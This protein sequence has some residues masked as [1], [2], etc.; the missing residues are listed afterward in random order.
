MRVEPTNRVP[1]NLSPLHKASQATEPSSTSLYSQKLSF[2][3]NK[4]LNS[5]TRHYIHA[6]LPWTNK[7]M[8]V[9][10]CW[11]PRALTTLNMKGWTTKCSP[12]RHAEQLTRKKEHPQC[13]NGNMPLQ[14]VP[15][16]IEAVRSVWGLKNQMEVTILK[17][18]YLLRK[19]VWGIC[20]CIGFDLP[21]VLRRFG[22]PW[23]CTDTGNWIC[24]EMLCWDNTFFT[25][26]RALFL[27][28]LKLKMTDNGIKQTK[29]L[30]KQCRFCACDSLAFFFRRMLSGIH[31]MKGLLVCTAKERSIMYG[32]NKNK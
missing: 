6:Q 9:D 10:T 30:K 24:Y 12:N 17:D 5:Q 13:G 22:M 31:L 4:I 32:L 25:E 23:L 15:K 20:G 1:Q 21:T 3:Q 28:I 19:F 18:V 16:K 27:F 29:K 8:S 14:T 11:I 7:T 26:V 2:E